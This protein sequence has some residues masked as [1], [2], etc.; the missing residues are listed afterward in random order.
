MMNIKMM[1]VAGLAF[2][3]GCGLSL[4]T[5]DDGSVG[6]R[7]S[8]NLRRKRGNR[9][10]SKHRR[11]TTNRNKNRININNNEDITEDV[12]FWTDWRMLQSSLPPSPSPPTPSPTT[13]TLSSA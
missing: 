11:V 5:G 3:A 2:F 9:K 12:A 10:N 6:K 13:P 4:A 1:A 7:Y 8:R